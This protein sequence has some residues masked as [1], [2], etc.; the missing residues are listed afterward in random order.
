MLAAGLVPDLPAGPCSTLSSASTRSGTSPGTTGKK[1]SPFNFIIPQVLTFVF[2][3]GHLD[4][5]DLARLDP[6]S[7]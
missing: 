6:G 4:R 5:V 1:A 3:L 7:P 2:L